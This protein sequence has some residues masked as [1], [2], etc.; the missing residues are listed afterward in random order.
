MTRSD[1]RADSTIKCLTRRHSP[2]VRVLPQGQR[3]TRVSLC[4]VLAVALAACGRSHAPAAVPSG[5]QTAVTATIGDK[6]TSPRVLQDGATVDPVLGTI[7]GSPIHLSAVRARL[8]QAE[9]E[10]AIG[11]G[12]AT[13]LLAA[14]ADLVCL[15]EFAVLDLKPKAGEPMHIAVDRLLAGTWPA[16]AG[17]RVDPA[18]LKMAFLGHPVRWRHPT[19]L[20]LWEAQIICCDECTNVELDRC[21]RKTEA[22]VKA[23]HSAL[24]KAIPPPLAVT[25]ATLA[26]S[27]ARRAHV[28]A[29][30]RALADSSMT[31]MPKLLR[32]TAFAREQAFRKLA[33]RRTDIPLERATLPLPIGALTNPIRT[34]TGWSIAMVV[35]HEDPLHG[36]LRSKH[37]QRGL[38]A[39][40]C[41]AQAAGQRTAYRDR[42]LKKALLVW[43]RAAVRAHLGADADEALPQPYRRPVPTLPRD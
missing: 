8:N 31:P 29:F 13:A 43:D 10:L 30:E 34:A 20:T 39:E 22:D 38:R 23:L 15:R 4:V 36:G 12:E 2:R 19:A 17:C 33:F 1:H 35:G 16:H 3:P 7:D 41:K 18:D 37:T 28:P 21:Q 6:V 9:T 32:Y 40:V 26:D 24:A 25:R 14:A 5:S 42:M 11:K 27:P